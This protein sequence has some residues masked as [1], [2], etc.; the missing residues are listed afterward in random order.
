MYINFQKKL[1]NFIILYTWYNKKITKSLVKYFK[2]IPNNP[3]YTFG[4]TLDR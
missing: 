2:N 1:T 4:G 3:G